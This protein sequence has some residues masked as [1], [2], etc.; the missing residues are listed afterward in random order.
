VEWL[1]MLWVVLL[2]GVFG[3]DDA[4][5][6]GSLVAGGGLASGLGSY[7]NGKK[8]ANRSARRCRTT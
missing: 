7:F 6:G 4:I 2:L 8:Q 3:I 1:D 5:L